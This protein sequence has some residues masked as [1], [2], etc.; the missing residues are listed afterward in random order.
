MDQS[1]NSNHPTLQSLRMTP[2]MWLQIRDHLGEWLPNEGCGLLAGRIS[3]EGRGTAIQFFPGRNVLHSPTRFRM[4]DA[5]LIDAFRVIREAGL[6]LIAIVHSHPRTDPGPSPTDLAEFHYPDAAML[7]VGYGTGEPEPAA[8][9]V[10][11]SQ[12]SGFRSIAFVVAREDS[13][14]CVSL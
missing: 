7:I 14:G 10:D 11:R 6:T 8:W 12:Q 5:E 2:A 9:V 13:D 4:A 1:T 3:G